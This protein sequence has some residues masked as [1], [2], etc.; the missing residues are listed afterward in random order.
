MKDDFTLWFST[1]VHYGAGKVSELGSLLR[2]FNASKILIVT[3]RGIVASGI[4]K[5]CTDALVSEHIRFSVFDGVEPNP[6]TDSVEKGL[7]LAKHESIHAIVAIGGGSSIDAAKAINV[8]LANGGQV[9]DYHGF[10]QVRK[11]GL[12]L[13]AIPTTAGTGSEMTSVMLISDSKT[14]QKIVCSDPKI[15]PDVAILDPTLTLSLPPA[16]TIESGLDALGSGIEAY[17]SKAA[18]VYSDVLALRATEIIANNIVKVY[19][20]PFNLDFRSEMLIGANMMGLAVHLSYIGAAHSMANPLTK[21]FGIRHGIAVGMV[22]P[23]VML[24]NTPWQPKK[25]KQ[26]ALALGVKLEKGE[27]DLTMGRKGAF[28]L[29]ILLDQ[30]SLPNNLLKM[31]VN[32]DLIPTMAHEALAQ[33]SIDYNPVKPD[34]QQ[35]TDLFY[36]AV[37]GEPSLATGI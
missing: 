36:S 25:Y 19:E 6:T 29:R 9:A 23:Y 11:K 2:S 33:L 27:D 26:I 34:L 16:V 4:L 24:F 21:H 10:N 14:H 3:D 22:L 8:L 37:R 30:L 31:G 28:K 13:I 17:V 18:N 15:I 1:T 12:P 32:E 5:K 20:E 7:T 35:M